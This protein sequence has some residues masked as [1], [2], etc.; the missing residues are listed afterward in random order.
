MLHILA[1]PYAS[2]MWANG[3]IEFRGHQDYCQVLVDPSQATAIDLA[4]VDGACLHELL[5]HNSVMAMFAGS[6]AHGRHLAPD[7]RM[8]QNVIRTRRFFHP[9]WI[10]LGEHPR[11]FN[12][13]VHVPLLVGVH[14]QPVLRPDSVA[15]Y[16][17]TPQV[18]DG[19]TAHHQLDVRPSLG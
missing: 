9:P 4:D 19:I 2:R 17:R 14:H 13:L 15:H 7:A 5:E 16:S 12:G 8:A 1:E 11:S 6:N 18:A 10:D 3:N